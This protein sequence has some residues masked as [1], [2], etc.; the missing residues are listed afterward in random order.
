MCCLQSGDADGEAG[1][2]HALAGESGD[3]V[4]VASAAA[5]RA[6]AHGAAFVVLDLEGQLG[7]EH[8]AGVILEAADNGLINANSIT[9]VACRVAK[10]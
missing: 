3:K 9:L 5:D 1:R 6:E 8:R 2:R 7:L 10:F 4:V